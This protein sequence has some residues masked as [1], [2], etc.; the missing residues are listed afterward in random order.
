M[1]NSNAI[2]P[3]YWNSH[4]LIFESVMEKNKN[5]HRISICCFDVGKLAVISKLTNE[6]SQILEGEYAREREREIEIERLP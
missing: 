3:L 6:I 2:L 4:V 1:K 5:K